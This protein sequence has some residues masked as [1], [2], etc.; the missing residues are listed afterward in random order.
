VDERRGPGDDPAAEPEAD[1]RGEEQTD[2]VRPRAS[3]P[4][5]DAAGAAKPRVS[6]H[7]R[8][9]DDWYVACTSAELD[10]RTPRA[11][12]L[13]DQSIVLF[14]DDQG[15]AHALLDRCPHRNIPLSEGKVVDGQLQCRYHGWRFDGRGACRHIPGLVGEPNQ[16]GRCAPHFATREQHG[17]VWVYA[18]PDAEPE[19]EPFSFEWV[20]KPGYTVIIDHFEADGTLHAIAENAL[21]VPHTAFVHAGLF[22]S[23]NA[24]PELEVEVRRWHDRCEAQYVGEPAPRGVVGRILAPQGGV[25]EHADRFRLPCIAEVDYR[26]GDKS[27]VNVCSAITPLTST[28]S[29]L[30]AITCVRLPILTS[31]V[32]ALVKPIARRIFAQDERVLASQVAT[33]ERFG[34]ERYVSTE[35]DAL[36]P[37]ILRLLRNAERGDRAPRAAP[38]EHRFTLRL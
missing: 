24:G 38:V 27:H 6:S 36:G 4:I 19:R 29:R 25:V 16:R 22:R 2:A 8:V 1:R 26:L 9:L 35:L 33:I 7:A 31:V 34:G 37:H 18:T 20:D 11:S 5:I 12:S 21:D 28:R 14:R 3:L 10:R 17:V 30:T 32:A 23:P 13:F 15:V